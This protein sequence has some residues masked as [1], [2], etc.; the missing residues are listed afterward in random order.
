M[1]LIRRRD[2][3]AFV[4]NT[5]T[6][7]VRIESSGLGRLTVPVTLRREGSVVATQEAVLT[8]GSVAKVVF[9]TKPDRIGEFVLLEQIGAGACG[10]V[11]KAR[12]PQLQRD[13]AIKIPQAG[14]VQDPDARAKYVEAFQRSDFDGAVE[15]LIQV[16]RRLDAATVDELASFDP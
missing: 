12:D 4:H 10:T 15:L 14:W 8:D 3:F 6:I 16:L 13:V 9:K 7:D 1:N 5:F 2:D 11:W